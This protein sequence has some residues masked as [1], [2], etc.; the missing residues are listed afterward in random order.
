MEKIFGYDIKDGKYVINEK[1]AEVVRFVFQKEVEYAEEPPEE[2]VLNVIEE[3][4]VDGKTISYER[5]KKQVSSYQ[6]QR[7]IVKEIKEKFSSC[8][9]QKGMQIRIK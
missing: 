5:A 4:E 8:F 7:Y 6:I 1:E 3:Y 9:E 2:L